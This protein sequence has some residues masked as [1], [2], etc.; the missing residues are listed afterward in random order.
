MSGWI[1]VLKEESPMVPCLF[2]RTYGEGFPRGL[3]LT[4]LLFTVFISD[5][6]D[7]I[8]GTLPFAGD[9][10]AGRCRR[11]RRAVK[12]QNDEFQNELNGFNLN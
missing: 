12:I 5:L 10:Q 8:E 6:E 9:T 3:V 2:G 1:A 4:P 11:W 7:G